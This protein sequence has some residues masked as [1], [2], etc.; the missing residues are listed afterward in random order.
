MATLIVELLSAFYGEITILKFYFISF[1]YLLYLLSLHYE[2]GLKTTLCGIFL[3]I[4][5]V[6]ICLL[7]DMIS[8]HT[9]KYDYQCI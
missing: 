9:L 2:S 3:F 4:Y 5:Y 8:L 6:N 1:L 7:I